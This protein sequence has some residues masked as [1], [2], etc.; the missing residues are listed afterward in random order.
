MKNGP[1]STVCHA[2]RLMMLRNSQAAWHALQWTALKDVRMLQGSLYELYGGVLVQ[3]NQ[4]GGHGL[5]FRRLP[6]YYRN[7]EEHV[8]SLELDFVLR[9]FT[10][11]PAQ[12]LLVL[13]AQPVLR[14]VIHLQH[15][16]ILTC[17]QTRCTRCTVRNVD[18]STL[19]HDGQSAP[20]GNTVARARTRRRSAHCESDV[21]APGAR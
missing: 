16:C 7:I 3:S 19:P 21:Y 15:S 8:W 9:D 18:T 1:P 5:V 12:D 10:L 6:S 14:Q 11:D 4:L 2:D 13:I 20:T 17:S